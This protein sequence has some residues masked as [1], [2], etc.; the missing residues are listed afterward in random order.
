MSYR[1]EF[2]EFL[3]IAE[4][5]LEDTITWYSSQLSDL[6]AKF[7]LSV[8]N[9]LSLILKTPKMFPC[10]HREVRKATL[11]DF[12]FSIIYEIHEPE[13]ILVLAIAHQKRNPTRWINR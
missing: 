3:E 5:E 11:S 4:I 10:V 13:V 12:P 8:D 9:L 7:L 6:D 2:L 1:V